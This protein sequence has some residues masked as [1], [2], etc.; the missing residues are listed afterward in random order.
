MTAEKLYEILTF[1][2]T[3]DKNLRLQKTLEAVRSALTSLANQPAQPQHQSA[4]AA[5]LAELDTAAAKLGESITPS[6]YAMIGAMGGE[7]FFDPD[8]ADTVTEA[9]RM[10][11][12][13]PSVA[14]DFVE[15]LATQRAEFLSTIKNA[16]QSLGELGITA[17]TLA[18]GS[19]DL[20]FLIPRDMFDNKLVQFAKELNFISRL[21]QDFSEALTG[22]AEHVKLEQLSSSAP[23]VALLASVPVIGALAVVINKFLEAW[24][25]IEKIRKIRAELTEIGM[26]GKA[27]EEL[28]EQITTT[29]E[30]VVEES[31]KVVFSKYQGPTDRRNELTNAVRQDVKR[32]FGQIERGLTVEFRAQPEKDEDPEE[33][34]SLTNISDLARKMQFPQI[35]PE[36]MLLTS[37]EILEGEIHTVKQS[38]KTTTQKTTVSKKAA[39]KDGGSAE[40]NE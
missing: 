9:V 26:R 29:V 32:L 36:P 39:H 5:A 19:A 27:V 10:N 14:K 16:R 33:Q 37:G 12:M 8:I 2:E 20:A 7:R 13:T 4:L 11:A 3:L 18:P 24:E 30:Q 40:T 17:S 22:E 38:K 35:A 23:T 21:L 31:T 34:K 6:Q 15:E 25:K 1:L 28:T